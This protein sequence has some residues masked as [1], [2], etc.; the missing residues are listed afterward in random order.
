M[1]PQQLD[2]TLE[3]GL[4]VL[5]D[6]LDRVAVRVAYRSHTHSS[7]NSSQLSLA[8]LRGRLIEYQL[9]MA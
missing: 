4:D 9:R 3:L 7:T 1:R 8:S 6:R 2:V 5:K